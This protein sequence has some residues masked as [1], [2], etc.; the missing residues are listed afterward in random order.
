MERKKLEVLIYLVVFALS[1]YVLK[2]KVLNNSHL[3]KGIG[4][5]FNLPIL[6]MVFLSL[7]YLGE[8][9]RF[10]R[11]RALFLSFTFAIMLL[12]RFLR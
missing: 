3:E 11:R 10:F 4:L 12:G 9:T 5:I 1:L 8:K 2:T 7:S 6:V